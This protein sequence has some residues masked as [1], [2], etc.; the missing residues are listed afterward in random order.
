MT[1]GDGGKQILGHRTAK[2]ESELYHELQRPINKKSYA[3][4]DL[5]NYRQT[6]AYI[7]RQ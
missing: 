3:C 6:Q 7:F 2:T 1:L 4:I 5:H